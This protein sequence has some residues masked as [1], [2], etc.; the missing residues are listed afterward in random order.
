MTLFAIL[1]SCEGPLLMLASECRMSPADGGRKRNPTSG[2]RC[3]ATQPTGGSVSSALA[4]W[5]LGH[6]EHANNRN[7]RKSCG[8]R[9]R[10]CAVSGHPDR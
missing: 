6:W 5:P 9:P 4:A 1:S 10:L 3:A 8:S 7:D 2:S